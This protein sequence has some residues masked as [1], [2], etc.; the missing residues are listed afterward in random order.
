MKIIIHDLI[1]LWNNGFTYKNLPLVHYHQ[2]YGDNSIN[3]SYIANKKLINHRF[4]YNDTEKYI[5]ND[6]VKRILWNLR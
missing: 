3:I 1:N 5:P 2:T 4:A 6:E